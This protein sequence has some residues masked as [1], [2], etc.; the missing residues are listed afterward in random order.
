MEWVVSTPLS[1]TPGL[2]PSFSANHYHQFQQFPSFS[3]SGL[4]PRIPRTVYRYF[5]AYPFFLFVF[6][7]FPFSVVGS[8]RLSKLNYASFWAHV[9]TA[10][11][12]VSVTYPRP[13][14][15]A[16][17][18]SS[19]SFFWFSLWTFGDLTSRPHS[20]FEKPDPTSLYDVVFRHKSSTSTRIQRIQYAGEN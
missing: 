1:F 7:F 9:K 17:N 12:I 2:K 14:K 13:A 3:S 5:W 20:E 16:M 15:D 19:P 10:S 6:L 4:T 8:V 11:R 18:N